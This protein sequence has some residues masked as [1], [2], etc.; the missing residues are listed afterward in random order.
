MKKNARVHCSKNFR[1][2]SLRR[3]GTAK[4]HS[5]VMRFS[6]ANC[7]SK[8]IGRRNFHRFE[9]V[10]ALIRQIYVIGSVVELRKGQ[11]ALRAGARTALPTSLVQE[12]NQYASG[13]TR[14]C[15]I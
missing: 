5:A 6:C 4:N 15:G 9:P 12:E 13:R 1:G 14:R 10:C 7:I 11:S 2:N 3:H 8:F